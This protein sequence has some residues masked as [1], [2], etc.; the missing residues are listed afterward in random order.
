MIFETVRDAI[1]QQLEMDPATITMDSK[2]TEDL[3][4]DSV[5]VIEIVMNLE[6]EFGLEFAFDDLGELTTVGDVVRYIEAH[7][8]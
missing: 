2:L 7:K 8:V 1:A 4:T 6:S 5:D 3:K